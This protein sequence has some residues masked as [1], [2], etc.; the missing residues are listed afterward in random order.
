[1][2]ASITDFTHFAEL[3][4]GAENN[5]PK[6]L[7]EVA[8]QFEALFLQ[9]M[10]KNMREASLGDPIFG[11][12]DSHE[13]Y[14]SMLDQQLAM[15]MASGNGIGLAEMLVRQLGGEQAA[16]LPIERTFAIERARPASFARSEPAWADAESFARD[17]WPHAKRIAARLNV[18]PEGVLAQAALETGWGKHV[19]A[20]RDGESSF[21]LFGIKAGSDWSGDSVARRTLEFDGGVARHEFAQFRA[22]GGVGE[23]F[24]DY[25]DLLTA[26]PRY[27]DVRDHGANIASFANALQSSGYA[28]DPKYADKI[29]R[30]ASSDT[31]TRVLDSLKD[32]TDAPIG[33]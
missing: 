17:V 9:S 8:G 10:L 3:R 26:N 29:S 13:M 27:S 33:H 19:M 4:R 14:Q 24:D 20:R 6:V 11:E 32:A 22:Y 15:E 18:A 2:T 12:S 21:N 31:M 16:K 30:V 5:D 7:K 25:A 28:T 1:M 23:T